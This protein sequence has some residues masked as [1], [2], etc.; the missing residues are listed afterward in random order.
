VFYAARPGDTLLDI[1]S[2][3]DVP[4]ETLT[5]YNGLAPGAL[6][7]AGQ[8]IV[9]ATR[10]PPTATS[11]NPTPPVLAPGV[12]L[13]EDATP[14]QIM[15]RML[16]SE[17][18]WITLWVDA[19]IRDFGPRGY[20][21]PPAVRRE[22]I[23]INQ[24]FQS[25]VVTGPMGE[26]PDQIWLATDGRVYDV[27]MD[28]GKPIFYDF[29]GNRLPVYSDLIDMLFPDTFAERQADI[30]SVG[31]EEVA[32]RETLVLDWVPIGEGTA[33]RVWL[34]TQTGVILRM[35]LMDEQPTRWTTRVLE[36]TDIE[37][38]A[39]LPPEVFDRRA[40]LLTYTRGPDGVPVAP[41]ATGADPGFPADQAHRPLPKKPLPPGFNPSF[42]TLTFQWRNFPQR[43]Q[44]VPVEVFADDYFLG[45]ITT[46]DPSSVVCTRSPD[47][48]MLALM[49]WS[50]SYETQRV[51]LR[52]YRLLDLTNGMRRSLGVTGTTTFAFS[53]NSRF[54]ALNGCTAEP[55]C[56]LHVLDTATSAIRTVFKGPQIDPLKGL[57]WGPEGEE[58]AI[59]RPRPGPDLPWPLLVIRV[60]DGEVIYAGEYDPTLG[61]VP[62]GSPPASWGVPFPA[63]LGGLEACAASPAR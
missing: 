49:S 61:R 14:E 27:E 33:S 17:Q 1:S 42:S 30:R 7:E 13:S 54:L 21:G 62:E 36:V 45:E 57:V 52:W 55:V 9:V 22:Q 10:P 19:Q 35:Q 51:G 6:L 11:Q 28:T 41:N 32:G 60:S 50:D 12:R 3:L 47:G 18:M 2:R 56:G 20:V 15:A 39:S 34:D 29:H 37:Y 38:N 59:L 40:P 26:E 46:A 23:W 53:P 25:L 43:G 16:E 44:E 5:D 48:R 24:P 58:L 8:P 31:M 63:T 4:I